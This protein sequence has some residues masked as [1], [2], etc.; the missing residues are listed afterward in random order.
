M[1]SQRS[2]YGSVENGKVVQTLRN[3]RLTLKSGMWF[4]G[5]RVN[6]PAENGTMRISSVFRPR[7]MAENAKSG[8]T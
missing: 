2:L 8:V 7:F 3:L 1:E 5:C 6:I 4:S